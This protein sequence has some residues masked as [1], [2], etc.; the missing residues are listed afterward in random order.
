GGTDTVVPVAPALEFR[1][2]APPTPDVALRPRLQRAVLRRAC[3]YRGCPALAGGASRGKWRA[4]SDPASASRLRRRGC[5]AGA[6]PSGGRLP[7]QAG[8]GGSAA[9]LL[10]ANESGVY[11]SPVAEVGDLRLHG[12]AVGLPWCAD[13]VDRA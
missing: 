6:A 11:R 9:L 10:H 4:G 2:P 1:L 13:T 5:R 12:R 7:G 3:P 8:R